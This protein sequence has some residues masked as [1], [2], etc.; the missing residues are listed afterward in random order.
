MARVAPLVLV[1]VLLVATAAAFAVSQRRKLEEIPVAGPSID[2]RAFSPGCRCPSPA[3]EVGFRLNRNET[4]DVLLVG[5]AGEV[6]R[7]LARALERRPGRIRFA[8]DGR[9]DAG[10]V[11][12]DGTYHLRVRLREEERTVDT[13]AR[14]D[15]DA[16]SPRAA[17]VSARPRSF[18]VGHGRVLVGYRLSERAR[19]ELHVNGRRVVGP[20]RARS[21]GFLEWWGRIDERPAPPGRYRLTLVARDAAGNA[22][23]RTPPVVVL[24]G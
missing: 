10:E 18:S 1:L 24:I 7:T 8:W 3:A 11:V 15:V 12:P 9:D 23:P 13:P 6:A 4:I 17:I 21:S 2:P 14:V 22:S 16:T 20:A 19:P 5:E